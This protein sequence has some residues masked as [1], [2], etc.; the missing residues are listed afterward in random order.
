RSQATWGTLSDSASARSWRFSAFVARSNRRKKKPSWT[1]QSPDFKSAHLK[2]PQHRCSMANQ[3]YNPECPEHLSIEFTVDEFEN[4][5]AFLATSGIGEKQI[6]MLRKCG[7]VAPVTRSPGFE[8]LFQAC[9]ADAGVHVL[10]PYRSGCVD[11]L[12]Q[13]V[14]G[15]CGAGTWPRLAK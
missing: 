12:K 4:L 10:A 9:K 7:F 8:W 11:A 5:L 3:Y 1:E 2:V 14:D 13:Y 15:K 6:E